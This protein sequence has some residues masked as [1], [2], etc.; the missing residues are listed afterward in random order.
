MNAAIV[1][2]LCVGCFAVGYLVGATR[3]HI[4]NQRALDQVDEWV[5]RQKL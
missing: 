5:R 4:A 1:V 3:A 2:A